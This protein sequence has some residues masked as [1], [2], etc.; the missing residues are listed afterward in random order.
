MKKLILSTLALTICAVGLVGCS[1]PENVDAAKP[2]VPANQAAQVLTIYAAPDAKSTVLG[3]INANTQVPYITIFRKGEWFE[4]LNQDTG[5]VGW[6]NP[7]RLKATVTPAQ[8]ALILM[9]QQMEQMQQQFI[10]NMRLLHQQE[11]EMSQHLQA[12]SIS[13][14]NAQH[15]QSTSITYKG[16]G[17]DGSAEVT[18][19]WKDEQ[20]KWQTNTYTIPADKI[21]QITIVNGKVLSS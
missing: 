7:P 16:N 13:P 3:Q 8:Q 9:Q 5:E 12:M 1:H 11:L 10:N 20:G 15:Y 17:K 14:E 2:P 18:N 4:V 6:I 19:T 21:N